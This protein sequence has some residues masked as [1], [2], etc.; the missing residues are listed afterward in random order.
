M[1]NRPVSA[2]SAGEDGDGDDVAELHDRPDHREEDGGRSLTSWNTSRSNTGSWPR[3]AMRKPMPDDR[4]RPAPTRTRSTGC[5]WTVG[6]R[7]P[8]DRIRGPTSGPV[9][10]TCVVMRPV[11]SA[12][13]RAPAGSSGPCARAGVT[14]RCRPRRPAGPWSLPGGGSPGQGGRCPAPMWCRGRAGRRRDAGCAER[15]RV[16]RLRR[17]S[18]APGLRRPSGRDRPFRTRVPRA[19][20]WWSALLGASV[21]G[22]VLV[23]ALTAG[24]GLTEADHHLD[25]LVA[26]AGARPWLEDL[27]DAATTAGYR[28]LWVPT[29]L[30]LAWFARWRHLL[31]YGGT[32]S[33]DRGGGP[34]GRG[35]E[36]L[37][38]GRPGGRDRVGGAPGAAGVAPPRPRCGGRRQHARPRPSPGGPAGGAGRRWR[39]CSSSSWRC[40]GA[41]D[42]DPVAVSA[43]SAL[44]GVSLVALAI[45]LLAPEADFPVVYHRE[46]KAHLRLDEARTRAHPCG[47]PRP[48]RRGGLGSGAL[49]AGRLRRFHALP[50]PGGVGPPALPV[51]QALRHQPPAVRPLVQVRPGAALRPAGGRGAVLLGPPA[52]GAARTTSC[53]CCA[54]AGVRVPAPVGVVEVLPGREYL[55]VCELVPGSVEIL[56][57]RATSCRTR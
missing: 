34:G 3:W 18:P 35:R 43:L 36:L 17:P 30:V 54:T 16:A 50:A 4:Q 14:R 15:A 32:I 57:A 26:T 29:V 37:A 38:A 51:R 27:Q 28:L 31:V 47:R 5:R 55:L 45:L 11:H 52:G 41:V 56:D 1:R 48:A 24:R 46:V 12:A 6:I 13:Q 20:W 33:G 42:L 23:T 44:A 2:D 21:L 39:R 9:A 49:P 8:V 40:A 19:V 53:G 10:A 7:S 22:L 25:E